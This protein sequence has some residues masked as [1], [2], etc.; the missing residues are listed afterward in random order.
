VAKEWRAISSIRLWLPL[1]LRSFSPLFCLL[2]FVPDEQPNAKRTTEH[3]RERENAGVGELHGLFR[4]VQC[5]IKSWQK[6]NEA[7]TMKLMLMLFFQK[8]QP[9]QLLRLWIVFATP[10]GIRPWQVGWQA[11]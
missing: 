11:W 1:R 10:P 8:E 5:V 2:L 3:R 7:A 6:R 9:L 4:F